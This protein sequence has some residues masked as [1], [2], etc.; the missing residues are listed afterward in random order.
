[1]KWV[2]SGGQRF[3]TTLDKRAIMCCAQALAQY[4]QTNQVV[5]IEMKEQI[6]VI[7]TMQGTSVSW[8]EYLQ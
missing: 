6:K 7:N 8:K 1:V 3:I 5:T 4:R 2:T